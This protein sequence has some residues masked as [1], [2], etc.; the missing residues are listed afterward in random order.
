MGFTPRQ[1]PAFRRLIAEAAAFC[2]IDR[3]AQNYR[4]WYEAALERAV[5]KTSTTECD[6]GS[7]YD[8]VMAQFEAMSGAGIKWQLRAASGDAKRM[9]HEI[10]KTCGARADVDEAYM[11]RIGAQALRMD[12]CPAL[13]LLTREQREIILVACKQHVT[14]GQVAQL[15]REPQVSEMT[16]KW[17]RGQAKAF[18]EAMDAHSSIEVDEPF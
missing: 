18:R 15:E 16:D 12:R 10:R 17:K 9:L 11:L 14:R 13:Y 8:W 6:A 1:Q 3:K 2:G 5:G 7:D 4:P